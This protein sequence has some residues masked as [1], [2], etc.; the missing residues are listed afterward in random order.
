MTIRITSGVRQAM[1]DHGYLCH[2]EE[3]CGLLSGPS[4]RDIRQAIPT[5]NVLHSPTNY[6]IDPEEHLRAVRSSDEQGWEIV[7]VFHSHPHSAGYPSVTDVSLAPDP[8]WLYL[9]VGMDDYEQPTVRGFRIADRK[10]TEEQL[11][12]EEDET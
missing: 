5:T 12:F 3:A 10:I 4:S 6:T 11:E 1:V 8:S 2:P 7:G 9:L